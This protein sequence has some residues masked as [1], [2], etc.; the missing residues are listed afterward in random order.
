M[1]KLSDRLCIMY[2][3]SY[4]NPHLVGMAPAEGGMTI[5]VE[6]SASCD[7]TYLGLVRK[8]GREDKIS[9]K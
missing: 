9:A 8:G 7:V 6:R 3:R 2:N 5:M 1:E 4:E